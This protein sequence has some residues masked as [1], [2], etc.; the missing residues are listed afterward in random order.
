MGFG[1]QSV[2]IFTVFT[3]N[4]R[5]VCVL[6]PEDEQKEDID[7]FDGITRMVSTS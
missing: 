3:N 6:K 7:S 1:I 4:T 5:E 2:N